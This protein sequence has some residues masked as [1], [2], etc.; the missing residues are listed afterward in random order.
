MLERSEV[1]ARLRE[2][3]EQENPALRWD[4][5]CNGSARALVVFVGPSPGS[6]PHDRQQWR[7]RKRNCAC[8]PSSLGACTRTGRS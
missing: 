1:A 2:M 8:E 6:R 7:P 3:R 4:Q 5:Q